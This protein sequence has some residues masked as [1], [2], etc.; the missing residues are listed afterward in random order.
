[1]VIHKQVIENIFGI[2]G[3]PRKI[4]HSCWGRVLTVELQY[5]KLVVYYETEPEADQEFPSY[6]VAV[7]TGKEIPQPLGKEPKYI[8][9]LMFENNSYVLHFYTDK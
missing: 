9:T 7:E 2:V 4:Y 6:L 3:I 1:M 5:G 8:R